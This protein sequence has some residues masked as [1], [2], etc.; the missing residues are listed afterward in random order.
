[1]EN[2]AYFDVRAMLEVALTT[3]NFE[4]LEKVV[5]HMETMDPYGLVPYHFNFDNWRIIPALTCL[6]IELGIG[7]LGL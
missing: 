3:D 2:Y 6:Y 1:M 5:N 7:I 4:L